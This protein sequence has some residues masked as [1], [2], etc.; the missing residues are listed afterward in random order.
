MKRFEILA[1]FLA[2]VFTQCIYSQKNN[3]MNYNKLTPQEEAVL[4]HKATERPFTGEYWRE[5]REGEYVCRR[6]NA[7]LYKSEDKFESHCGWASF[8]DEVSGAVKQLPD[9]DGM[10]TEIVC[11]NCGGHLGHIFLGEGFTP[12]NTR[13]CVN[14]LSLIFHPKAD[15]NIDTAYFASGCFWGTEYFFQKAKGVKYTAVGFM[16]G[17]IDN[18][19][20]E[21]VCTG[22]TGHIET[23]EV[24]FDKRETSYE[25][26]AKLFFETH[27]F[28]Q[29]NGQG[30]DIGSQYLSR[31]FYGNE[32]Q[33]SIAE[34]L[35]SILAT[36][37]YKVATKLLP[38]ERFWRAENYHQQY[39][40]H[41]GTKPYCHTYRK[42]F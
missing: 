42:I 8:D 35:V 32:E 40:E 30:P 15:E 29:T 5:T 26:L 19:S 4:L 1:I 27:D 37:G 36:K 3:D 11:G 38:S 14:S 34:K 2:I 20:Y 24:I 39:Y 33:K 17:S 41:K 25:A 16:G 7:L 13:H 31:I 9:A 6:C 18:P 21:E 23:T 12:K 28:T 10:R 22:T